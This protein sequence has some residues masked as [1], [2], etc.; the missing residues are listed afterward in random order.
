MVHYSGVLGLEADASEI[1]NWLACYLK[2]NE[3]CKVSYEKNTIVLERIR[4]NEVYDL[5]RA[6]EVFYLRLYDVVEVDD[7]IDKN[8]YGAKVKLVF[9]NANRFYAF[10]RHFTAE[11]PKGVIPRLK[12]YLCRLH[13]HS[14]HK[15]R[16]G[17]KGEL[18]F[19]CYDELFSEM[20]Q[21]LPE[22]ISMLDIGVIDD[23]DSDDTYYGQTTIFFTDDKWKAKFYEFFFRSEDKWTRSFLQDRG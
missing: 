21:N 15:Y 5:K 22:V 9:P 18:I 20:A 4:V 12:L 7:G 16:T 14:W 23:D 8:R 1:A 19:Q 17:P 10:K 6:V 13:R 11:L 3:F 2:T